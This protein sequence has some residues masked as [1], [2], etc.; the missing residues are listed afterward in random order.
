MTRSMPRRRHVGPYRVR[1]TLGTGRTATVYLA[2]APDRRA[3]AVKVFHAAGTASMR[4]PGAREAELGRWLAHPTLLRVEASGTDATGGHERQYVVF[5]YVRGATLTEVLRRRRRLPAERLLEVARD[6]IDALETLHGAGV[7]HLD[8]KPDNVWIGRDGTTRLLDLGSSRLRSGDSDVDTAGGGG[9]FPYVAPEQ[10]D[11]AMVDGRADLF[12]V[13]TTLVEAL[14]GPAVRRACPWPWTAA[15]RLRRAR[16]V[17]PSLVALLGRMVDPDAD[18][19]PPDAAACRAELET[20]GVRARP[21]ASPPHERPASSPRAGCVATIA[22]SLSAAPRPHGAVL[23]LVGTA[24]SGKSYLA[25]AVAERARELGGFVTLADAPASGDPRRSAD[26]PAS[27]APASSGARAWIVED[28]DRRGRAARAALAAQVRAAA[29]RGTNVLLTSTDECAVR[30]SFPTA[31]CLEVP[32]LELPELRSLLAD[33]LGI[34]GAE[35]WS[36]S[37]MRASGGHPLT[38]IEAAAE[39]GA[40]ASSRPPWIR[41]VRRARADG[42]RLLPCLVRRRL[43]DLPRDARGVVDVA[44]CAGAEGDL[45]ALASAL[46]QTE[47]RVRAS[48]ERGARTGLLRVT[49]RRWVFSHDGVLELVRALVPPAVSAEAHGAFARA[50]LA[51]PGLDGEALREAARH[52]AQSGDPELLGA[53]GMDV[54]ARLFEGGEVDAALATAVA[55][56]DAECLDDSPASTVLRWRCAA[57]SS[58][59]GSVREAETWARDAVAC[60]RRTGDET[61]HARSLGVLAQVLAET[62]RRESLAVRRRAEAAAARAGDRATVRRCRVMRLWAELPARPP[63]ATVRAAA[64]L[65]GEATRAHDAEAATLARVVLAIARLE[66]GDREGAARVAARAQADARSAGL[67]M[68][69][70]LAGPVEVLALARAGRTAEAEAALARLA[71]AARHRG[72][73]ADVGRVELVRASVLGAAG[74]YAEQRQAAS[75]AR[76]LLREAGATTADAIQ[77]EIAL[78]EAAIG[79]GRPDDARRHARRAIEAAA[80]V[81]ARED[82]GDA[83]A[84]AASAAVTAGSLREAARAV[85]ALAA[86]ARRTRRPTLAW[87]AVLLRARTAV[88]A[89]RRADARRLLRRVLAAGPGAGVPVDVVAESRRLHR[90]CAATADASAGRVREPSPP[91]SRADEVG[92]ASSARA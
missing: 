21:G 42:G 17:P 25:R 61:L 60:A 7:L 3:V 92:A 59:A 33:H 53:H 45:A 34:A 70:S 5:P 77:V 47:D 57:T 24:G 88:R 4:S 82:V 10:C 41:T 8:V 20:L 51:N 39:L 35:R 28:V 32:P 65:V 74:R 66:G 19:R 6:L 31:R 50:Q 52:L 1:R 16:G 23:A 14:V 27:A 75:R 11:G 71:D 87:R 78:G 49:E 89:R 2:D 72:L 30:A 18:R 36:E 22:R 79:E 90:A 12:A 48:L 29:S 83:L 64:T 62:D 40:R 86:E 44:A 76:S 55:T 69:A 46:G 85:H 26:A 67:W 80:T 68:A 91:N 84:V 54:A 43:D 9:T 56:R 63:A 13:G 58:H 15:D 38:A 81:G 37:V 73:E